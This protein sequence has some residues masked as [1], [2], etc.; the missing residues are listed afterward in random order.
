M[1]Q[2]VLPLCF[3]ASILRRVFPKPC[4]PVTWPWNLQYRAG[5]VERR[6]V[7]WPG[8]LQYRAGG[9]ER[10]PA[11]Y[12]LTEV[13]TSN[14]YYL[15]GNQDSCLHR[16]QF[17]SSRIT[18]LVLLPS[19][20][21]RRLRRGQFFGERRPRTRS[22]IQAVCANIGCSSILSTSSQFNGQSASYS[23]DSVSRI[24]TTGLRLSP[25]PGRSPSG[26]PSSPDHHRHFYQA[27]V[28]STQ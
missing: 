2:A 9:V 6:P 18:P 25:Y 11:I 7:P 21:S 17:C 4:R 1:A 20:M 15:R 19:G 26:P 3:R 14:P 23:A 16:R 12:R 22:V 5:V 13:C 8:N 24:G 28:R 10:R 27:C